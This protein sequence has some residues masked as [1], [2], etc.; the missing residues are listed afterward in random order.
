M[1]RLRSPFFYTVVFLS[2]M[3]IAAAAGFMG[4]RVGAAKNAELYIENLCGRF[5]AATKYL[6]ETDA[7]Q[8]AF[9]FTGK[10][11]SE[12][13]A[14]GEEYLSLY[15]YNSKMNI[16]SLSDY[17]DTA[18]AQGGY[19][20]L[21]AAAAFA[22]S[23]I[24]LVIILRRYFSELKN[25]SDK[26]EQIPSGKIFVSDGQLY[27]ALNNCSG[28]L[29]RVSDYVKT[30]ENR[31]DREDKY[32]RR[33][34]SDISHQ[35]KN[36]VAAVRI[37]QEIILDEPDMPLTTREDFLQRSLA[38]LDHLEWLISGLLKSAR[39]DS[40]AIQFDLREN[41]LRTAAEEA[42][43][44]YSAE[45]AQKNITLEN[46]VSNDIS[47]IMD[48]RWLSE[49]LGNLVKNSVE[50]T[51]EG[52]RIAID[53]AETPLTVTLFVKDNGSG[54]DPKIIPRIFERFYSGSDRKD[55]GKNTGIGLSVTKSIVERLGGS[56]RASSGQNGTVFTITFLRM[57]EI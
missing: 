17:R 40:G 47:M 35:M 25:I 24:L 34:I 20:A 15:G 5:G 45:A 23:G 38:Q 43:S 4:G 11:S 13:I 53:A 22:F 1:G 56:I 54:I 26:A 51:D 21:I 31:I 37:N 46:N 33:L 6:S 42:L 50:H 55:S 3:L 48:L 28:A 49:A 2:A 19:C 29:S 9:E 36:P 18:S 8:A 44:A 52:G 14:R 10:Y 16:R 32:I 57:K 30:L 41:K 12:D 39:L 7:K 27:G